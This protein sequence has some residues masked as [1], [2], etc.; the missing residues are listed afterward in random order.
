MVRNCTAEFSKTSYLDKDAFPL[1]EHE[2]DSTDMSSKINSTTSPTDF[3]FR[4]DLIE[5][6]GANEQTC[7]ETTFI[8]QKLWDHLF[9]MACYAVKCS[10][11]IENI[12][13]IN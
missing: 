9:D 7:A 4:F 8:P 10:P 13:P 3:A 5:Y 12:D 6:E 1:S 2:I 11:T